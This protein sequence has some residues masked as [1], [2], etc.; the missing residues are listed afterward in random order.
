MT[1]EEKKK[2]LE[3]IDKNIEALKI[4]Y[5]VDNWNDYRKDI[6]ENEKQTKRN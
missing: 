3:R 6:K 2:I 4:G 1:K 5:G